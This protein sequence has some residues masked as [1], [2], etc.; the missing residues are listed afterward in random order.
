MR[1]FT[2][3]GA[4]GLMAGALA[5]TTAAC[6]GTDS[7]DAAGGGPGASD[8]GG[9]GGGASDGGSGDEGSWPRTVEH[10]LGKTKIP[11]KPAKIV[12][13]ALSATGTLLAIDA[14]LY[15]SAATEPS[16]ITDDKGFFS[17]WAKEA[18]ERGVKVLYKNLEFD[19]EAIIDAEPDLVIVSVA[20]NDSQADNYEQ[21]SELFACVGINYDTQSWQELATQ[22]GG[23]LGLE[24]EAKK[25]TE[26]F[27]A[28]TADAKEKITPNDGGASVVSFNGPGQ[29]QGIGK[30]T[31]AHA[32]LLGE[33]GIDV[34]EAPED[35]DTSEQKRED[36]AF[37]SYEN[38]STA[39]TGDSVFLLTGTEDTVKKFSTDKVL[40]NLPAVQDKQVYPLGPTSFRI[41]YYSGKLL[42][43]EVVKSLG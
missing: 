13:T 33:L 1:T 36:F 12:N 15:A 6:S 24:A 9:S 3:R 8:G 18:D 2:R 26:G 10:E 28:Y 5:L 43:D 38:L 14:P 21:I 11:A 16:P 17:Q 22:L 37:V 29:D 41:D 4:V 40:A 19:L 23:W 32:A 34:V 27:D 31:G 25:A 35:L 20:G 39:I 30:K 42:V 7:D